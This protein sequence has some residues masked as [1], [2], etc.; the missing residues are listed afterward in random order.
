M[1]KENKTE[2]DEVIAR[3]VCEFKGEEARRVI[4]Y[5][6]KE[7]LRNLA[8]VGYKLI[9]DGLEAASSHSQQAA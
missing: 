3:V 4:A 5:K 2:D 6:E 8:A 7:R 9:L 1:D